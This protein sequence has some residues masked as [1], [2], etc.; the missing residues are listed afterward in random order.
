LGVD[1]GVGRLRVVLVG[2][3][4]RHVI[5]KLAENA[6]EQRAVFGRPIHDAANIQPD[7]ATLDGV[8]RLHTRSIAQFTEGARL[9]PS[10][11]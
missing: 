5:L 11:P 10:S 9:D 8:D 2:L 3:K 4:T 7:L 6:I 1:R